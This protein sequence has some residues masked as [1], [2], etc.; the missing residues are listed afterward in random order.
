MFDTKNC[1]VCGENDP[2][3][4]GIN[5]CALTCQSCKAFFRRN[6][7]KLMTRKCRFGDN[8]QITVK[9]RKFCKKCRLSKCLA[10]GMNKDWILS[11]EEKHVRRLRMLDNRKR[12]QRITDQNTAADSDDR[13]PMTTTTTTTTCLSPDSTRT[14]ATT[15]SGGE[16]ADSLLS[17]DDLL[18]SDCSTKSPDYCRRTGTTDVIQMSANYDKPKNAKTYRLMAIEVELMLYSIPK[19]IADDNSLTDVETSLMC[20]L[21]GALSVDKSSSSSDLSYAIPLNT[22]EE[23]YEFCGH[24]FDDFLANIVRIA[25]HLRPFANVCDNDQLALVKY[26][27]LEIQMLRAWLWYDKWTHCW[28]IEKDNNN[29]IMFP[30]DLLKGSNNN[31]LYIELNNYINKIID[32]FDICVL[33]LLVAIVLFNPDR[34][35]LIYPDIVKVQQ[36]LYLYLLHRYMNCKYSSS[37]PFEA[38]SK[39]LV[40]LN[41]LETI[42]TL[43]EIHRENL[44]QINRS[45]NGPLLREIL[46][47]N[48]TND[49]P[50]YSIS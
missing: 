18:S 50:V 29:G 38:K 19:P 14:T 20:E 43:N 44:I 46:D 10:V 15:N 30:I 3:I 1:L 39:F 48:S 21:F 9:S 16:S 26:G 13:P 12:R 25:R 36:Q 28:T 6:A 32:D 2:E 27:C 23:L 47:I 22:I 17:F 31:L 11:E 7:S 49:I 37:P 4:L 5:F 41:L 40:A 35:N 42:E 45:N 33:N 8:C 24:K 34:P